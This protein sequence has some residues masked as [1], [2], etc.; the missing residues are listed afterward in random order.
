MLPMPGKELLDDFF[1]EMFLKRDR[2][3]NEL[4]IDVLH[5]D[6]FLFFLD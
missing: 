6:V 1:L 4:S 5:G 3:L 2:V